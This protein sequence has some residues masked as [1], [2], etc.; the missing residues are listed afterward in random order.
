MVKKTRYQIEYYPQ[1][2]I[3]SNFSLD[4]E[5]VGNDLKEIEYDGSNMN[6]LQILLDYLDHNLNKVRHS[7]WY[8]IQWA[9][10]SGGIQFSE[11]R[12][13]LALVV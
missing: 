10:N 8:Y 2:I 1:L 11:P 3:L 9:K 7:Y 4:K 12:L 6:A 5:F 13:S